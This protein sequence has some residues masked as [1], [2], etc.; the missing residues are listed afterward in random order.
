MHVHW[1]RKFSQKAPVW[2]AISNTIIYHMFTYTLHTWRTAYAFKIIIAYFS[3]CRARARN[4]TLHTY[5]Y[6]V[7]YQCGGGT[8]AVHCARMLTRCERIQ[9][10]HFFPSKC[11]CVAA[12]SAC[13]IPLRRRYSCDYR[14]SLMK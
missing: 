8:A 10:L 9:P 3:L 11:T 14:I 4:L 13:A 7:R 5:I 2:G 12:S 6:L 1:K